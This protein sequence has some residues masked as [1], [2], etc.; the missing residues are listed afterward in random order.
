MV[1]NLL[2]FSKDEAYGFCANSI[3]TGHHV[4]QQK[5]NPTFIEKLKQ[6]GY[7]SIEVETGEFMKSGGGIHCLTNI[8]ETKDI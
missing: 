7:A 6:L 4:I 3:V 2:E 1:P 8:L 5:G